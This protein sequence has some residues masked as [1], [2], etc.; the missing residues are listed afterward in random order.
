MTLSAGRRFGPYEILAP[1]GAGGM[2]E[3][4][5]AR[6]VRLGRD[7]AIKVLPAT[8]R[9]RPGAPAALRAGGARHRRAQRSE[10][11]RGLRRGQRRRTALCRRRSCSTAKRWGARW[12][13]GPLPLRKAVGYAQQ[14][15][16]GMAAAHRRGI[17]HRDMKPEN[18]FVTHDGLVKILDFGLAKL[19]EPVEVLHGAMSTTAPG[20]VLGTVGYMSPEQAKGEQCGRSVR[21]LLVWRRAL[22]NARRAAGLPGRLAGRNA[23]G[24]P[25][26]AALRPHAGGAGTHAGARAHRRSLSR[27]EAGRSLSDR[28]RSRLCA[29]RDLRFLDA[30]HRAA[31]PLACVLALDC[32]R[33]LRS[34]LAIGGA[35]FVG[36]RFGPTR[37]RGSTSSP[38]GAARC[39]ARDLPPTARP[40]SSRPH[41]KA[42]RANCSR[43]GPRRLRR[44][45]CR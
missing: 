36:A 23:L 13:A 5:R 16:R 9:R 28:G 4:Y 44:A 20:M 22:R 1:L 40:S 17:V 27:E 42:G 24:D 3:V 2:G 41:G 38:S 12:R 43:R 31:A 26:R 14:I 34:A 15:A 6:D 21:H 37:S 45:R 29:R 18:L 8:L 7:V 30:G 39:R 11:R 33:D 25:E 35:F 32:R 10:H 19:T